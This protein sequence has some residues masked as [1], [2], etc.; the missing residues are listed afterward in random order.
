MAIFCNLN[1]GFMAKRGHYI[2]AQT[3]TISEPRYLSR[4]NLCKN[5]YSSIKSSLLNKNTPNLAKIFG[6]EIVGRKFGRLSMK[7]H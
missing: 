3:F 4:Y 1:I 7:T 2:L 5:V 6:C